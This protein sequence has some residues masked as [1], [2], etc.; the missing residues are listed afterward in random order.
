MNIGSA[1]ER[2][3]ERLV[4]LAETD[5]R[6]IGLFLYGS[7]AAGGAD[8]HSDV[9]IGLVTTDDAHPEV[10]ASAPELVAS[11]GEPLFLES[12]DDPAHL[13]AILADGVELELM[14]QREAELELDRPHRVLVDKLGSMTARRS[15]HT[16]AEAAEA[17][18]GAELRRLIQWFWHDLGH[19][20]TALAREQ[21]WWAHGQLEELRGVCLDL[22]R[23]G[24][25]VPLEPGE[26]YWKVDGAVQ[27]DVLDRLADTVVPLDLARMRTAA[28]DLITLYRQLARPLAAQYGVPYPDELDTLLTGRLEALRTT[29]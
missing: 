18:Q 1:N 13:H 20:V 15:G 26:P 28:L 12:F 5:A 22:A 14:V 16:K 7:H 2:L 6:V 17:S 4:Q 3:V 27:T 9:D 29:R 8:E 19:V 21:P 23:L 24:A 25:G 10:V 11:L